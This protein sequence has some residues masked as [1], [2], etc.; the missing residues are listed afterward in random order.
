MTVVERVGGA[1]ENQKQ[2]DSK[3]AANSTGRIVSQTILLLIPPSVPCFQTLWNSMA[4]EVGQ[5]RNSPTRDGA[6]VRDKSAP[7]A[8]EGARDRP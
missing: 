1:D 6:M 5:Y 7:E 8:V 4:Q 3:V 2:P